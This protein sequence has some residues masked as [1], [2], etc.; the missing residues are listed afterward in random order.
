M[1]SIRSLKLPDAC[2]TAIAKVTAFDRKTAHALMVDTLQSA[3]D[4]ALA[5]QQFYGDGEALYQQ[6]LQT[7]AVFSRSDV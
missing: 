6:A 4:D 7:N 1:R 2:K 5:R 3:S